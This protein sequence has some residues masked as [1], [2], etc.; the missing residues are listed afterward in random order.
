MD[1]FNIFRTTNIWIISEFKVFSTEVISEINLLLTQKY[2]IIKWTNSQ[3]GYEPLE[4]DQ[5]I[6]NNGFFVA[7]WK[8]IYEDRGFSSDKFTNGMTNCSKIIKGR[9]ILFPLT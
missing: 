5:I 8:E 9:F 1:G 4:L 3:H 6:S 7:P 2:Y